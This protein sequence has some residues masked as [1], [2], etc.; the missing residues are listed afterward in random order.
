MLFGHILQTVHYLTFSKEKDPLKTLKIL[1][2]RTD[3]GR[4]TACWDQLLRPCVTKC[5]CSALEITM[6]PKYKSLCSQF[7]APRADMHFSE[8][9]EYKDSALRVSANK[10][11]QG[12][13]DGSTKSWC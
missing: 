10:H 11:R 1:M 7:F 12:Q 6:L 2:Q 13:K 4:E 8:K 9:S 3:S 5:D